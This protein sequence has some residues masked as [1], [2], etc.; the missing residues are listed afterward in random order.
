M[1][2]LGLKKGEPECLIVCV[3]THY[4]TPFLRPSAYKARAWE[5]SLLD[6]GLNK[7]VRVTPE[8]KV[9][10]SFLGQICSFHSVLGL[11]CVPGFL[12][13]F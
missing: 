2:K 8:P 3:I 5:A 11:L 7:S 4:G 10:N 1:M 6:V 9:D 12:N 13:F